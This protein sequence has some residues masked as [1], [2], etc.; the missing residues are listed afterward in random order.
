M[1]TSLDTTQMGKPFAVVGTA[2]MSS[3]A[4]C[5]PCAFAG[6]YPLLPLRPAP[7]APHLFYDGAAGSRGGALCQ[8]LLRARRVVVV[9]DCASLPTAVFSSFWL[10]C[11]SMSLCG[12]CTMR[13]LRT[14]KPSASATARTHTERPEHSVRC[15]RAHTAAAT[16]LQHTPLLLLVLLLETHATC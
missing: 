11:C 5:V 14:Q 15:P 2:C 13:N 3:P 7:W 4:M 9:V 1:F 12:G 10:V 6:D 8:E 16:H